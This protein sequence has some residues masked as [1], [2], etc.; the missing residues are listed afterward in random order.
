MPFKA[1]A[2][3]GR[4]AP[5]WDPPLLTNEDRMP[6]DTES[7]LKEFRPLVLGPLRLDGG[8][9]PPTLR[10]TRIAGARVMDISG[11]TLTLQP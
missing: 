2:L 5:A 9:G 11:I 6:R 8:R 4:V 7:Y 1:S 10:S 3:T